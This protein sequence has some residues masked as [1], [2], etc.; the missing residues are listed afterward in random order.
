MRYC[1][2]CIKRLPFFNLVWQR[3]TCNKEKP[4]VCPHCR[5][6]ISPA[7]G[8]S[9]WLPSVIAPVG[10]YLFATFSAEFSVKTVMLSLVIGLI[11]FILSSYFTAPLKK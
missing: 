8:A 5:S 2:Y 1:P 11:L 6:V 9:M 3:L 10:G 4:L 7:G